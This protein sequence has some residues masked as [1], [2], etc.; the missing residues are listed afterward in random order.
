MKKFVSAMLASLLL[1]CMVSISANAMNPITSGT[2]L[3]K[4]GYTISYEDQ[5]FY[6]DELGPYH[7]LII[8]GKGAMKDYGWDCIAPE[9]PWYGGWSYT[10]EVEKG[11]TYIGNYAFAKMYNLSKVTLAEGVDSIGDYTFWDCSYLKSI[12]IP[13]SV[14]EIG[15]HA[16]Q[17]A[18]RVKF[19]CNSDSYASKYAKEHDIGCEYLD[20]VSATGISLNT[21]KL[22]VSRGKTSKLT[23]TLTPSNVTDKTVRWVSSEPNIARVSDTGQV[24]GISGGKATVTATT[25]NG[26][27]ARC[28]VTVPYQ[29]TYKLNGGKNHGKNPS[30]YTTGQVVLKNP[31]RRNYTF[32]GWYSDQGYRSKIT[33]I[34]GKDQTVYAKWKKVSVK[35]ASAPTLTNKKGKKLKIDIKKVSG[36]AGYQIKYATNSNFKNAVSKTTKNRTMTYTLKKGKTYYVRVRAYKLDSTGGK[37]YGKWSSVKKI[38]IKK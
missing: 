6:E 13:D 9:S 34:S 19:R 28:T 24:T 14:K 27:M 32:A 11:I 20:A 1:A 30:S 18:N 12:E 2:V 35:K 33:R 10:I 26:K 37:V 15:E 8:S 21:S 25:A 7:K 3:S 22:T 31:A 4:E 36:A 5:S 16:F 29:I 23:A 17:N 38:K